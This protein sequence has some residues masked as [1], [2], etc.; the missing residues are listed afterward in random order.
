M[1]LI[2]SFVSS[3]T[4]SKLPITTLLTLIDMSG[5]I[6]KAAKSAIQHRKYLQIGIIDDDEDSLFTPIPVQDRILKLPSKSQRLLHLEEKLLL[7][8][9]LEALAVGTLEE[10][11]NGQGIRIRRI[12]ECGN[13][14]FLLV[15]WIILRCC[16]NLVHL[17]L[18]DDY[19]VPETEYPRLQSLKCGKLTSAVVSRAPNL[20]HIECTEISLE[21]IRRLPTN[22]ET[23]I[24]GSTWHNASSLSK[25]MSHMIN[26]RH[27]GIRVAGADA[28]GIEKLL[29]NFVRLESAN[30]K[31]DLRDAKQE[32]VALYLL[33]DYM[34]KENPYLKRLKISTIYLTDESLEHLSRL[35]NLETLDITCRDAS[36]EMVQFPRTWY[37]VPLGFTTAGVIQ[38]LRTGLNRKLQHLILRSEGS[39]PDIDFAAVGEELRKIRQVTGQDI[40]YVIDGNGIRIGEQH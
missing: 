8:D 3:V 13:R 25:A 32:D 10:S 18:H 26:L 14:R 9:R 37:K 11:V 29:F 31:L 19:F 16:N 1:N 20:K 23:Y 12:H 6:G 38:F 28:N 15:N 27:V 17:T 36:N 35:Q 7:M 30:L 2:A 5:P 21:T 24:D 4:M 22:I 33:F 34:C 40:D 39:L